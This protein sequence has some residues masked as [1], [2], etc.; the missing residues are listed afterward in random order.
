MNIDDLKRVCVVGAGTMGRQIALHNAI[1]GYEVWLTDA[2]PAVL[3]NART[4]KDEYLA[5]RVAKGRLT[6]EQVEAADRRLHIVSDLT[7]AA[8]QADLVIEAVVEKLDVKREVFRTLDRIA[9]PHAI[10]ATNSSTIVSSKIADVTERP[11]QVAN[12]HYF[13]PA[14]VMQLVE[15]VQG[16]HTSVETAATLVE[17]VRRTGKIPIWLKKEISGFVAN[18]LLHALSREACYL[19]ENGIA[20]VEEVDLAAEKALG[21]PMG[22]F[23]L[24][25]NNG[26]DVAYLVRKQ[27][28]EETGR[29][30]DRPPR[31]IEE[32]YLR[33][34]LGRKTGKGFYD[35]SQQG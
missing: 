18:R 17:F 19:V 24:M 28:Y 32:K 16:P 23:R 12:L 22:P 15:V 4:W 5:G 34:E 1:H 21:H 27:R 7:E 10:L 35:Y 33:G 31:I 3:E 2:S 25:D 30:E 6:Q 9:P 29:E 11:S 8:S 26:I 20:T 13:N 14:L